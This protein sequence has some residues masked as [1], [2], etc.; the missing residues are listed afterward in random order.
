M[1]TEN[2]MAAVIWQFIFGLVVIILLFPIFFALGTSFKPLE[3]V[4]SNVLNIIPLSPTLEN[5]VQL[6]DRLPLLKIIMNNFT[7]ATAVT[8][9]KL[10]TCFM[11][12]Y[13]FVFLILNGNEDSIF[14]LSL[15]SLFHLQ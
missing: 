12:A 14:C 13:A 8:L 11:A 4:Y 9:L 6:F 7:I 5:Y 1:K 3:D 2:K 10:L 15:R